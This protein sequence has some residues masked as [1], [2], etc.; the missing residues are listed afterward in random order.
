MRNPREVLNAIRGTFS[1]A[2]R[3]PVNVLIENELA[4]A[5]CGMAEI[6][7]SVLDRLD[8][9]EAQPPARHGDCPRLSGAAG[10]YGTVPFRSKSRKPRNPEQEVT[11]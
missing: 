4:E 11:R 8:K 7:E 2:R 9:L 1:P 6:V 3:R 5:V 10:E